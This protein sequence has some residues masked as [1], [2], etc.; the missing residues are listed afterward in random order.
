MRSAVLLLLVL[1]VP[2][3]A[4]SLKPE[5]A[6]NT[7]PVF[8]DTYRVGM[9]LFENR[10][11]DT[12]KDYL[13][14]S[15][16]LMLKEGIKKNV[17]YILSRDTLLGKTDKIDWDR[18]DRKLG[19]RKDSNVPAPLD[20]DGRPFSR[21]ETPVRD[22]Q[23]RQQ[24]SLRVR[25][26]YSSEVVRRNENSLAEVAK[27][28]NMHFLLYGEYSI[29]T[30]RR[31]L[32]RAFFY[33]AVTGRTVHAA[34]HEFAP[35]R[36]LLDLDKLVAKL[37]SALITMPTAT[38]RIITDPPGALV[39]FGTAHA[40]VTPLLLPHLAATN[41]ELFIRK[42]GY[43]PLTL[44]LTLAAGKKYLLEK[45]LV[46]AGGVGTL[47]VVSEPSGAEVRVDLILKGKTPLVISNMPAGTY[48]LSLELEKHHRTYQQV[49]VVKD[50]TVKSA[51]TLAPVVKGQ[52]TPTERSS[53][54]RKWMNVFFWSGT[55]SLLS[56]AYF[57]FQR[58][59]YTWQYWQA[60]N[61]GNSA[62]ALAAWDTRRGYS[63]AADISGG[64]TIGCFA[65]SAYFLI[66]HL[67]ADDLQVGMAPGGSM[68][69]VF[70]TSAPGHFAVNWRF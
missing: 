9:V 31:V 18:E 50:T 38:L 53:R 39:Y 68:P 60:M 34:S 65:V 12:N 69:D 47:E 62:A 10:T 54:F 56:Y 42:D 20:R 59:D 37:R 23:L 64:V 52:L 26:E 67:L 41:H 43:T 22:A 13:Q 55:G 16:P 14:L 40:G 4:M 7:A 45:K 63:I 2:L 5:E 35:G 17:D 61:N 25:L 19:Y 28:Q 66:R 30:G 33:N 44:Q 57:Y 24:A 51:V 29:T 49:T 3:G 6:T 70:A 11:G 58:E 1:A 21:R 15:L 32:V 46:P 8:L 36:A 27:K 48:R